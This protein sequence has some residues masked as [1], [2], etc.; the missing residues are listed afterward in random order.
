MREDKDYGAKWLLEH[1]GN[2]ALW[3]GGMRGFVSWR[4]DQAELTYP[5]QRPDG[6]LEVTFPGQERPDLF[7]IEVATYPE[8]R[9]EEQALRDAALVFLDR[10][11]MPEVI[12]L[13]LH[14]RG[15]R[16]VGAWRQEVS[17]LGRTRMR[18]EWT[19][20]NLWQVPAEDLLA[21]N[22][23]G[24]IP[25]VPLTHFTQGPANVLRRCRERIDEAATPEERGNL[26]AVTQIMAGLRY[27]DPGLLAILGGKLAMIESPVLMELLQERERATRQAD[28]LSALK[29]RF[30]T[31][32]DDLATRVRSIQDDNRLQAL[33]DTAIDCPDLDAFTATLPGPS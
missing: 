12:V 21:S 18:G 26:L 22:D 24:V 32:P 33:H 14:P 10:R 8:E 1:H 16:Q 11:V 5:L 17:R 31:V 13:V 9:A 28:I 29:R 27:N 6:L 4:P 19:V 20:V 15:A 23:V 3:L 7:V 25:W 2:V 30:G